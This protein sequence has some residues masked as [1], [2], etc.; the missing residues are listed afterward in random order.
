M[1]RSLVLA[2]L[3]C[4][5]TLLCSDATAAENDRTGIA[6]VGGVEVRWI[7]KT[8]PGLVVIAQNLEESFV[9][10]V[11]LWTPRVCDGVVYPP[12]ED[13][14]PGVKTSLHEGLDTMEL[15]GRNQWD[16]IVYPLDLKFPSAPPH[17]DV[18]CETRVDVKIYRVGHKEVSHEIN[19]PAPVPMAD[20]DRR[21]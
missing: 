14:I 5:S 10:V 17:S 21:P 2:A 1:M 8:G 3:A 9:R 19:A 18:V 16:L 13:K 15:S 12:T 20:S 6:V 7:V 4:V 11:T